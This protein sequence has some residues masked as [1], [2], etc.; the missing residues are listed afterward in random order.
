MSPDKLTSV[1]D[2]NYLPTLLAQPNLS[3]EIKAALPELF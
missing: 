1:D 3:A 2:P